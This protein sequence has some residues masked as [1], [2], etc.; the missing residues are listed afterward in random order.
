[1]QLLPPRETRVRLPEQPEYLQV[2]SR[3]FVP[4]FPIWKD[5]DSEDSELKAI[6]MMIR[7]IDKPSVLLI[8]F[9]YPYAKARTQIRVNDIPRC[10]THLLCSQ[11][12]GTYGT[13]FI[14]TYRIA[15]KIFAPTK[16]DARCHSGGLCCAERNWLELDWSSR[17]GYVMGAST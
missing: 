17:H 15:C 2:L 8:V 12:H 6:S 3:G 1:M 4:A 7:S 5:Q 9:P 13:E 14:V 10:G 16:T 11:P